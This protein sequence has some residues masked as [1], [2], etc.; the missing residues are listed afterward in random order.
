MK[1]S[2]YK[3]FLLL[4]LTVAFAFSLFT[5]G[6]GAVTRARVGAREGDSVDSSAHDTTDENHGGMGTNV[7]TGNDGHIGEN[8]GTGEF[9]DDTTH[10]DT[11]HSGTDSAVGDHNKETDHNTSE[12]PVESIVGGAANG[13]ADI[14]D[15]AAGAVDNATGGMSVW[16]IVIAII[17]I[18]AIAILVFALFSRRK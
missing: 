5:L 1:K 3:K 2:I 13:A 17:I 15:N 6:V 9:G 16:G 4:T 11:T 10:N 8:S 14:V 12:G 18:A 7:D